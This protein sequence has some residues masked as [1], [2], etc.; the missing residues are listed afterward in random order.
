M[1]EDKESTFDALDTLELSLLAVG[2]MLSTMQI[3]AEQMRYAAAGGLMAATDLADWLARRGLPF[4]EAHAV[5]GGLVLLAEKTERMLQQ[6]TLDELQ[7]ACPLFDQTVL[8]ALEI[9]AV[10]AARTTF[11]GTAPEQVREQLLLAKAALA[12]VSK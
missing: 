11:G 9:P 3:N 5:V 7:E 4:R 2:G 1:Q 10:V 8:A 12:G 6:L